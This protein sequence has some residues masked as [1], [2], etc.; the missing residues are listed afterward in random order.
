MMDH[1]GPGPVLLQGAPLLLG[2]PPHTVP[3]PLVALPE[4][5]V[6][7]I[8]KSRYVREELSTVVD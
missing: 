6:E 5:H 7:R 1:S 2:M 4:E 3:H 8:Q